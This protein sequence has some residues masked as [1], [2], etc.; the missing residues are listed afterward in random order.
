MRKIAHYVDP[1]IAVTTRE[2]IGQS[3]SINIIDW[4]LRSFVCCGI[5][6]N[7]MDFGK[8]QPKVNNKDRHYCF[9]EVELG[10]EGQRPLAEGLHT[11]KLYRST[12]GAIPQLVFSAVKRWF[13]NYYDAMCYVFSIC[14]VATCTASLYS[15]VFLLLFRWVA[16]TRYPLSYPSNRASDT[17]RRYLKDLHSGG[18]ADSTVPGRVRRFRRLCAGNS[19]RQ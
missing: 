4:F 2:N 19:F 10:E 15:L 7:I 1:W 12:L 13:R 8:L 5:H 6:A 3:I 18:R 17:D 9:S 14:K 16:H 11:R